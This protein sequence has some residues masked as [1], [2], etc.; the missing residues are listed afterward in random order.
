[1]ENI[2]KYVKALIK[3]VKDILAALGMEVEFSL[4]FGL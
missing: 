3:F 1:M 4:P 2:I